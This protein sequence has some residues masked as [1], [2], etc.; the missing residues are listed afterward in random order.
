MGGRG[1]GRRPKL[2]REVHETIVKHLKAGAFK[3]HAAKAA[4]VSVRAVEEWVKRGQAGEK[5]YAAFAAEVERL[6]AEDAIRNQAVISAA[7]LKP[8][9]G[10]WK[11]AAWSLERKYP[12]LYGRA[13]SLSPQFGVTIGTGGGE[14]DDDSGGSSTKTRVEFYLPD[15][16]RRPLE[17]QDED[18]EEA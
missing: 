17:D 18:D 1:S 10:D 7:A 6:Q 9:A 15:N 8:I 16:G 3:V 11:A 2:T 13:A 12:L 14:D 5:K 4:G